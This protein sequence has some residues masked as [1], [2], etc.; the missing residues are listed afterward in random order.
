MVP[1]KGG[2]PLPS[3]QGPSIL[4]RRVLLR[5]LLVAAPSRRVWLHG[6][7]SEVIEGGGFLSASSSSGLPPAWGLGTRVL[8]TVRGPSIQSNLTPYPKAA[9]N[10]SMR[11]L[12]LVCVFSDLELVCVL[13]TAFMFLSRCEAVNPTL[14]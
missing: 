11:D 13:A 2:L 10:A 12:E 5:V 3:T 8:R 6:Q 1:S 9:P 7:H 4:I 14:S